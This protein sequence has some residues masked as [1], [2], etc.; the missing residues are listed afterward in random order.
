MRALLA[1]ALF[2]L[3]MHLSMRTI[4][5]L[6]RILDLWYR[7]GT[8]W[9]QVLRGLLGWGGGTVAIAALLPGGLRPF[10]LWGLA[11]FLGVFLGAYVI[12]FFIIQ[13]VAWRRAHSDPVR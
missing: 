10:F 12:R 5:A 6:Y 9:P 8:A 3:G 2:L 13:A 4:A 7:I 11:A 1:V